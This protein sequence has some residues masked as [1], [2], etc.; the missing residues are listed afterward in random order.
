[1]DNIE[2]FDLIKETTSKLNIDELDDDILEN[3][4]L[5]IFNDLD[6]KTKF[7]VLSRSMENNENI[8]ID[9]NTLIESINNPN[10]LYYFN[11][12]FLLLISTLVWCYMDILSKMELLPDKNMDVFLI[13]LFE[14]LTTF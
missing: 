2:F 13:R 5:R 10:Y 11:M 7:Q 4:I 6:N 12:L 9:N 14:I 1:M 8:N 3:L